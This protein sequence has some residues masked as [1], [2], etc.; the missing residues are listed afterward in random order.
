MKKV[1][2]P[3]SETKVKAKALRVALNEELSRVGLWSPDAILVDSSLP[4]NGK[5]TSESS[6]VSLSLKKEEQKHTLSAPPSKYPSSFS[7]C[8]WDN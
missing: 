3:I 7:S 5:W 4:A 1:L 8:H 2:S 6:A